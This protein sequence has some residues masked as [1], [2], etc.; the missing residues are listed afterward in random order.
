MGNEPVWNTGH[1]SRDYEEAPR[2]NFDGIALGGLQKKVF[3]TDVK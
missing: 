2:V 1:I 3:V